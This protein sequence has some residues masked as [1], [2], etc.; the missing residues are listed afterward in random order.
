MSASPSRNGTSFAIEFDSRGTLR[1]EDHDCDRSHL[2]EVTYQRGLLGRATLNY[3]YGE[4]LLGKKAP[5]TVSHLD[6]IAMSIA[7]G[8]PPS[9][10]SDA[11]H[12]TRVVSSAGQRT[13]QVGF[14]HNAVLLSS[15]PT[16]RS[17]YRAHTR[18]VQSRGQPDERHGRC[19]REQGIPTL[20]HAPLKGT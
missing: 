12:S 1:L 18:V 11:E 10:Q 20:E 2:R 7:N 15:I 9:D 14:N 6:G 17:D 8:N 19:V 4:P 3:R 16:S 13:M 5:T